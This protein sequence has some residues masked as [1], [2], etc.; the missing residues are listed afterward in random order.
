MLSS[1]R[2]AVFL[3]N[4]HST[5]TLTWLPP[6]LVPLPGT[7]ETMY[8]ELVVVHCLPHLFHVNPSG[9]TLGT[10]D[11]CCFASMHQAKREQRI[12]GH[13]IFTI[14][15]LCYQTSLAEH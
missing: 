9:L 7:G 8:L 10:C 12:T 13:A 4:Q 15:V 2:L 5:V 3:F 14:P 1:K 11:H 6:S